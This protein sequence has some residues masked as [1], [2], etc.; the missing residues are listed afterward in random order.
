MSVRECEKLKP[1]RSIESFDTKPTI[2]GIA[3]DPY[4]SRKG[5][6]C[7]FGFCAVKLNSNYKL[8]SS[9]LVTY[10]APSSIKV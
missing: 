2:S 4:N 6:V 5:Q 7:Q 10:R 3:S 1:W 8:F 9:Q